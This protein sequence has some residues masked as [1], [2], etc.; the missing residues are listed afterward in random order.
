MAIAKS[1]TEQLKQIQNLLS[2]ATNSRQR[3]M[4]E[5]MLSK[6]KAQMKEEEEVSASSGKEL[7]V[8]SSEAGVNKLSVSEYSKVPKYAIATRAEEIL[9]HNQS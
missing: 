3:V 2:T 4:Y 8:V 9:S 1:K 5:G 7:G 6:L